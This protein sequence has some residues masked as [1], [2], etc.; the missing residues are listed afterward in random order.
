MSGEPTD[1][2]LFDWAR[3]FQRSTMGIARHLCPVDACGWYYDESSPYFVPK[4]G[5]YATADEFVRAM[6]LQHAA[7]IEAALKEHVDTHTPVEYLHTIQ[8]LSTELAVARSTQLGWHPP[9]TEA[10]VDG[11][12]R[13][14]WQLDQSRFADLPPLPNRATWE[15]S[16]EL[17]EV[18]R[19]Q[20][21]AALRGAGLTIEGA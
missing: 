6:A 21:I 15:T 1:G 5:P 8:R 16:P 10:Q 17:R 14:L 19:P 11:A 12:G 18:F 13:A 3:R 4:G 7:V 2:E 20:A 9:L